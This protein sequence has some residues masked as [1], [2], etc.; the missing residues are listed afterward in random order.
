MINAI[1]VA[2]FE[3]FGTPRQT[4]PSSGP[5]GISA[6]V[7]PLFTDGKLRTPERGNGPDQWQNYPKW[8]A[9]RTPPEIED[10][11]LHL[12][13][14]YHLGPIRIMWYLA[15][16]HGIKISDA[17]I[18]RILCR[19]NLNRL[20]RGTRTRKVHTKRYQKQVP[21]CPAVVC[22][23]NHERGHHIQ[24]DVKFLTFI[25]KAGENTRRFQYTAIDASRACNALPANG[26]DPGAGPQD[27]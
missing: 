3:F 22:N 19:H 21:H 17:C 23:A 26:C 13:R 20:P 15:R 16:Y 4:G 14:K 25:G 10:K 6:S 1:F 12:R 8:H 5:A 27:L 7:A 18:Y 2:N 11:A 24:M 9:N